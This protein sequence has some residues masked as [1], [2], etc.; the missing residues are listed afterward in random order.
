MVDRVDIFGDDETLEEPEVPKFLGVEQTALDKGAPVSEALTQIGE[1]SRMRYEM[2]RENLLNEA[3]LGAEEQIF[4]AYREFQQYGSPN[5]QYAGLSF[6][7]VL[8]GDD[9]LWNKRM[10]KIKKEMKTKLGKDKYTNNKFDAFFAQSEL[11]NK[12]KGTLE[13]VVQSYIQL[14]EALVTK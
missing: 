13:Q 11:R 6:N 7:K 10:N 8:D 1:Y 14:M 2:A 9:P 12:F 5:T 3:T 4:N